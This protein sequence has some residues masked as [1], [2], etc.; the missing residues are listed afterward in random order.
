MLVEVLEFI[1]SVPCRIHV[2]EPTKAFAL[3]TNQ[4]FEFTDRGSS[5]IEVL[6]CFKCW[7]RFLVKRDPASYLLPRKKQQQDCVGTMWKRKKPQ[8]QY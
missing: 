5:K 2:S 4:G 3:K 8:P 7:T 6:P 1:L